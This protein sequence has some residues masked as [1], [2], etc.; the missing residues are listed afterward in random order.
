MKKACLLLCIV[1][2]AKATFAQIENFAVSS[3]NSVVI[4][5]VYLGSLANINVNS[6]LQHDAG[7]SLRLGL[8]GRFEIN[9]ML[10]VR[11]YSVYDRSS[12]DQV[13]NN[14]ALRAQQSNVFI[15]AGRTSTPATQMRPL[16]PTAAGHFETYTQ[17]RLPGGSLGVKGG[18][19]FQEDQAITIGVFERNSLPEYGVNL[20]LNDF[21]VAAAYGV[22]QERI[23]LGASYQARNSF[24][25]VSLIGDEEDTILASL[26]VLDAIPQHA[27]QL[28]CDA[29]YSFK[30][31]DLPRLEIGVLKNFESEVLNGLFGLAWS[32]E[33]RSVK[34]YLFVHL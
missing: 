9:E 25:F 27:V 5:G 34:A 18:Y 12:Q 28:Y 29:G 7:H 4:E 31:K 13:I 11:A 33:I 17:S 32:Y 26:L 21:Q 3:D 30:Q 1:I 10:S 22:A 24:H 20:K 23:S 16:P 8:Q 14:F 2:L 6:D 15:E 19:I